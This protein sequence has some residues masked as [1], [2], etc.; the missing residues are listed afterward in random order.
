MLVACPAL[1]IMKTFRKLMKS[2]C[3]AQNFPAVVLVF[4]S[5]YPFCTYIPIKRRR[6]R[7]ILSFSIYLNSQFQHIFIRHPIQQ[8]QSPVP[9]HPHIH[10]HSHNKYPNVNKNYRVNEKQIKRDPSELY[11][12]MDGWTD[13][14][15]GFFLFRSFL[16]RHPFW[17]RFFWNI[18]K[19]RNSIFI[20]KQ[21]VMNFCC[22][23]NIDIFFSRTLCRREES[24]FMEPLVYR[25]NFINKLKTF[26]DTV[27]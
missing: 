4:S 5:F 22:E 27:I 12:W 19:V 14:D 21:N 17:G 25:R 16:R 13:F 8:L 15:S 11:E 18:Y 9:I 7:K 20:K 6:K 10:T 23:D 26:F 1:T 2:V 3:Y 24:D